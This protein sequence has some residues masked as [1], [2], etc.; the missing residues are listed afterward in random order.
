MNPIKYVS[1][2]VVEMREDA[3]RTNEAYAQAYRRCFEGTPEEVDRK[4][5][6]WDCTHRV[7][8]EQYRY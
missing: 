3:R 4:L 7:T 8:R 2:V 6:A 1:R 5:D